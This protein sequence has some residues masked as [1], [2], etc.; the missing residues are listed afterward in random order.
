MWAPVG[1]K[2]AHPP[3]SEMQALH[4]RLAA[5]H[6]RLDTPKSIAA[7]LKT[8][9]EEINWA[10]QQEP[11]PYTGGRALC[12]RGKSLGGSSSTT[13]HLSS[14]SAPGVRYLW[15]SWHSGWGI[16]TCCRIS[17]GWSGASARAMTHR[18]S[19]GHR[20][21][22]NGWRDSL[23]ESFRPSHQFGI[24]RNRLQRRHPG[25]RS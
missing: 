24:P 25:G 23:C 7:G 3:V 4:L 5:G 1:R 6:P 11:G 12:A 10:D 18:G 15:S 2:R 16:R 20:T 19:E 14:R 13:A 21:V 9:H 22:T 17:S 8:S